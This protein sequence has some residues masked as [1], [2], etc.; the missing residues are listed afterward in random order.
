MNDIFI[1]YRREG[2]ATTARL[3]C[4]A[5]EDKNFRCFFDSESLSHGSF[6]DNIKANLKN[7]RNFI[8]ILTPGA[9]ERCGSPDDWVRQEIA[10]AIDL[11]KSGKIKRL[12]PVFTNGVT[13]F[14][15][16]LPPDIR[17]IAEQNAIELNHKDFNVNFSRLIERIHHEK[18]DKLTNHLL[19]LHDEDDPKDLEYL[20]QTFKICLSPQD[21]MQALKS[22]IKMHWRGDVRELLSDYH[23]STLRNLA[24]LL[25]INQVG[26]RGTLLNHIEDWYVRDQQSNPDRAN[27]TKI[28]ECYL[29]KFPWELGGFCDQ[30][31]IKVD[32]RSVT[33]MRNF[34]SSRLELGLE[35]FGL[36]FVDLKAIAN[37]ALGEDKVQGY[38]KQELIELLT[39]TYEL[40]RHG[41]DS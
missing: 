29:D 35:F 3:I 18:R 25:G 17:P 34:L 24:A 20:H 5:L 31:G 9:L 21:Q 11:Y 28:L 36:S 26:G 22:S 19:D 16:D 1:S 4:Q 40:G 8:L 15:T 39:S 32:K 13:S 38:K 23:E 33:K 12:I 7:S 6:A 41:M 14:P 2:G 37:E 30:L 27:S 10:V